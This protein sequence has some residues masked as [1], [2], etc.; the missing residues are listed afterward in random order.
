MIT[1]IKTNLDLVY[2]EF[3]KDTVSLKKNRPGMVALGHRSQEDPRGQEDQSPSLAQ[4]K[5]LRPYLKQK[6]WGPGSSGRAL[7]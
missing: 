4:T 2:I 3:P 7:S 5:I 6:G 1:R